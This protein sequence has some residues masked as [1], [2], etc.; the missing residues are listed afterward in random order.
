M[1]SP[2]VS[3]FYPGHSFY[4]IQ[5]GQ[6]G[7]G[8]PPDFLIK[9]LNFTLSDPISR[10]FALDGVPISNSELVMLNGV[11]LAPVF[12]YSLVSNLLQINSSVGLVAGDKLLVR[13]YVNP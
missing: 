11:D 9:R 5:Q 7:S 4:Y 3:S 13:Y 12:D 8:V 6:G 2:V 10:D 1:D